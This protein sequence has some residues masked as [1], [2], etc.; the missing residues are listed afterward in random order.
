MWSPPSMSAPFIMF[1]NLESYRDLK[2][3]K[4]KQEMNHS[5]SVPSEQFIW[6]TSCLPTSFRL[7]RE[8]AALSLSVPFITTYKL[9]SVGVCVCATKTLV[10]SHS[11]NLAIWPQDWI[12]VSGNALT[13]RFCCTQKQ[14]LASGDLQGNTMPCLAMLCGAPR[15]CAPFDK[16]AWS[17]NQYGLETL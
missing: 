10:A 1:L 9:H 5:I 6:C 14:T 13:L 4:E 7:M 2:K 15:H 3:R 8:P 16:T 12:Y 11:G 17:R